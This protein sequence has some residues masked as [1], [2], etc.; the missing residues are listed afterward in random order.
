MAQG[1]VCRTAP[2]PP[3][4]DT[5]GGLLTAAT[6]S[7]SKGWS[8]RQVGWR[9]SAA[10]LGGRDAQLDQ[11]DQAG[12]RLS[13]APVARGGVDKDGR[14][15]LR[16]LSRGLGWAPGQVVGLVVE[17]GI[18]RLADLG[19]AFIAGEGTAARL[20]GRGRVRLA[21]AI[22]SATGLVVGTRVLLLRTIADGL[23]VLPLTRL[24]GSRTAT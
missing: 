14:V 24:G 23:L 17:D 12:R 15:P 22:R 7:A 21:D 19:G 11:K 6:Y 1:G 9:R 5:H 18:L 8:G 16:S 3:R 10:Q 4:K 20:D 13:A 2:N